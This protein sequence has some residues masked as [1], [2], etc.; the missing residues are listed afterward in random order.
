MDGFGEENVDYY[1]QLTPGKP[2]DFV[3][4]LRKGVSMKLTIQREGEDAVLTVSWPPSEPRPLRV[5]LGVGKR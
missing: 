5:E 3:V 4:R 2:A 1:Q